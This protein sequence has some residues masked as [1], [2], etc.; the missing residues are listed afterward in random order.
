[1]EALGPMIDKAVK[2][3]DLPPEA[4]EALERLRTV[5]AFC[6]KRLGGTDPTLVLTA[7]L[8][9]IAAALQAQISEVES[10]VN[11]RNASHLTNAN[12]SADTVIAQLSQIST[13]PSSEELIGLM[14]A[15]MSYRSDIEDRER[16]NIEARKRASAEIIELNSSLGALKAQTETSI[17][18]IRVL[19]DTER[20]KIAATAAE[21]QK[22]FADSQAAHNSTYSDIL[23]KIQDSLAKVLSDQQGQFSG[24]QENRNREFAATQS[25]AQ[26]RFA[27]LIADHTRRL[28]EADAVFTKE[29][30]G[31][32]TQ[33]KE[34]LSQLGVDYSGKAGLILKDV[35][36]RRG[37]VEKLVGVIGSLGV[38][39]GY[40]KTADS[41]RKSMWL[42]QGVAV[43]AMGAVIFFAFK[44]FLP[45]LQGAFSWETFAARVFLTITVGVLAAYAASQADRFFK[46]EKYN[47]KMALELAAIDP[48]IALLPP[49]E[50]Q[51]FKLEIGRR[52]F[53]Q[54]DVTSTDHKSP[55]TTLDVLSSKEGKEMFE[56][57]LDAA[58]KIVK[59]S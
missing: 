34:Q 21:Q 31:L 28:A 9:A 32:I 39:S 41:A 48:F 6:G 2:I 55:A 53:A 43:I 10:Y 13:L 40:Q 20:N 58:R 24:A 38:T 29:L 45:T 26:K 11:D 1:M 36:K 15:V 25:E 16:S 46:I 44:A 37:E 19:L 17:S 14:R 4:L 47:R 27:D 3:E 5:L 49:E 30:G 42:W 35:E 18:E 8:D 59:G 56:V 51:K 33:G 12:N 7:P 50:Q 22:L 54:E 57:M 52:S 23:A